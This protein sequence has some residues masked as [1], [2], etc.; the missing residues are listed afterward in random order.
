MRARL[1]MRESNF[2]KTD[3]AIGRAGPPVLLRLDAE[4]DLSER[5]S[6]PSRFEAECRAHQRLIV[7]LDAGRNANPGCSGGADLSQLPPCLLLIR[8]RAKRFL[9]VSTA[10]RQVSVPIIGCPQQGLS[11]S[12]R[13]RN[14]QQ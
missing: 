1:I 11:L 5:C 8:I 4:C 13:A 14:R 2:S 6:K 9:K 7:A 3:S 10:L 12:A